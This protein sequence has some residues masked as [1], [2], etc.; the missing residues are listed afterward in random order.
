MKV[1]CGVGGQRVSGGEANHVSGEPQPEESARS[2]PTQQA[3]RLRD[4]TEGGRG[5]LRESRWE[6]SLIKV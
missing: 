3:V 1:R 5:S 6:A 2:K 4:A